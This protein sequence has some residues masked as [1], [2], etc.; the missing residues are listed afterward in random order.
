MGQNSK[1]N[2]HENVNNTVGVTDDDP[3]AVS[4]NNEDFGRKFWDGPPDN[5]PTIHE[6]P[7]EVVVSDNNKLTEAPLETEC[8]KQCDGNVKTNTSCLPSVDQSLTSVDDQSEDFN[9]PLSPKSLFCSK[10]LDI[11]GKL[12][13]GVKDRGLEEV[14]TSNQLLG[15]LNKS[16]SAAL[17]EEVLATTN[18][19]ENVKRLS[20]AREELL[21][22]QLTIALNHGKESKNLIEECKQLKL[23]LQSEC[24]SARGTPVPSEGLSDQQVISPPCSGASAAQG[25]Q[26]SERL[27][28]YVRHNTSVLALNDPS[29]FPHVAIGSIPIPTPQAQGVPHVQAELSAGDPFFID[30]NQRYFQYKYPQWSLNQSND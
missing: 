30:K 5:L 15:D 3:P 11:G 9:L 23:E 10:V 22:Q 18:L 19:L 24:G 28:Q 26:D 29:P 6:S 14:K 27:S 2:G 8:V 1:Q 17:Q 16:A 12:D 25:L 7:D 4:V 21:N 13:T 20:K